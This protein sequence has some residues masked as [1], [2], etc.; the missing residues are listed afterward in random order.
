VFLPEDGTILNPLRY[1]QAIVRAFA[2]R[3]GE[4]RRDEVRAL[5]RDGERWELVSGRGSE[6]FSRVVVAAGAWS[7]RLLGPL[8]IR[9]PLESQRGYHAQFSGCAGL[10]S[11]SVVLADRKLFLAPMEDGLRVGGTVEIA[12]LDRPPDMRRAHLLERIVR[13]TFA[14]LTAATA[15]HWMGHRPCMPDSLPVI[16]PAAEPGLWLAVGH[17]HLGM[18]DSV[19][20]AQRLA[21]GM[22]GPLASTSSLPQPDQ[23]I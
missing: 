6:R 7:T 19:N 10:V 11:R 9:L 21:D 12:G 3:G 14:G 13:E 5:K 2:A 1:V 8:G 4:V 16:G 17:G 20:T 22:L 15:T 18:T 23:R